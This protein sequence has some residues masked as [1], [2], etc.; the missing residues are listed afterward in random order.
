MG[1]YKVRQSQMVVRYKTPEN[2]SI[3]IYVAVDGTNT[4]ELLKTIDGN[5]QNI[6]IS[7]PNIIR[8]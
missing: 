2:T 4:Y 5:E 6:K 8:Q 3:N 7:T 1:A